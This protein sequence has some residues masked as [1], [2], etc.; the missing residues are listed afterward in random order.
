MTAD[1]NA[2]K[3][4]SAVERMDACE[5]PLEII[6]VPLREHK[7]LK[8]TFFGNKHTNAERTELQSEE[9]SPVKINTLSCK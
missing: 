9:R 7:Q 1:F 4:Y 3:I 6:I 5:Y 8:Q 2:R